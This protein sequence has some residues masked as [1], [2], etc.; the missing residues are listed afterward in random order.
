[1]NRDET[2]LSHI[3]TAI[4]SIDTYLTGVT[5]EAF[6]QTPLVRDAVLRNLEIVSEASRRLSDDLKERY[7]N[8]PWSAVAAAGNVYRHDYHMLNVEVVWQTA[9][10]GLEGIREMLRAETDEA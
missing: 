7:P 8:V 1:M 4:S 10:A 3:A 2:Y 6:R 9:T 5:E